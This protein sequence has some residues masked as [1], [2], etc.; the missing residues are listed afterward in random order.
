[1]SSTPQT[2]RELPAMDSLVPSITTP[3]IQTIHNP[4]T[5]TSSLRVRFRMTTR[6][7]SQHQFRAKISSNS[8]SISS[9]SS[10]LSP[11][12]SS[13]ALS[14]CSYYPSKAILGGATRQPPFILETNCCSSEKM[15][16]QKV[17]EHQQTVWYYQND[18]CTTTTQNKLSANVANDQTVL[19]STNSSQTSDYTNIPINIGL[20]CTNRSSNKVRE[21]Q[22]V[23]FFNLSLTSITNYI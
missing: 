5:G 21:I 3:D 9:A 19:D 16:Y 1:M 10:C 12:S 18:N 17:N 11:S 20:N 23:R 22:N 6:Q 15:E 2:N 7:S 8:P 4:H 13:P 14:T